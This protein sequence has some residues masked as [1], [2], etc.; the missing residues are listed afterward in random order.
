MFEEEVDQ[1]NPGNSP[2]IA[3]TVIPG[4]LYQLIGEVL[5]FTAQVDQ[6]VSPRN[7]ARSNE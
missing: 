6:E 4:R 7:D 1:T 3:Q 5:S 2:K